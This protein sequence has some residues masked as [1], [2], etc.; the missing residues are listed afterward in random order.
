PNCIYSTEESIHVESIGIYEVEKNR[1]KDIGLE[2][3]PMSKQVE[4]LLPS[5]S[6]PSVFL[7]NCCTFNVAANDYPGYKPNCITSWM[8]LFRAQMWASMIVKI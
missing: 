7:G 4:H 1:D 8:S 2:P 6:P 5:L 3:F